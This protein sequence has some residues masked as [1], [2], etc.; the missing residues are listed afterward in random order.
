MY[1][2]VKKGEEDKG[3]SNLAKIVFLLQSNKCFLV[4]FFLE[5]RK[6]NPCVSF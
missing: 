2:V 6:V 5:L 1:S 3:V 4:F